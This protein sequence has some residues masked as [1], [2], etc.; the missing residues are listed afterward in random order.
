MQITFR[1][2]TEGHDESHRVLEREICEFVVLESAN[3]PVA[4]TNSNESRLHRT[5]AQEV[6]GHMH[7]CYV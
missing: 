3:Q 5:P 4:H 2:E 6:S 7:V 1:A